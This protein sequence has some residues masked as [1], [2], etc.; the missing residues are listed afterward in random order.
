[1]FI[2]RGDE[3]IERYCT[4]IQNVERRA[5]VAVREQREETAR[6]RDRRSQL[7][8]TLA[9]NLLDALRGG[10]D[11]LA[12]A[13]REVGEPGLR[14]YTEDP[15]ALSKPINEQRRDAQQARHSHL[16]QFAP[17]VLGALDPRPARGHEPLLQAIRHGGVPS[18]ARPAPV[19]RAREPAG[20]RPP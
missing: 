14:A 2:E 18:P 6:A 3:L 8:G 19:S 20:S 13:P 5:R 16:A 1:M 4:A 7:A 10:E 12:R 17:L 9:R 11:P 15:D